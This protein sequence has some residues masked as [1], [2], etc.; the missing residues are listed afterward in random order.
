ML[1]LSYAFNKNTKSK[2]VDDPE[3]EPGI[4]SRAL[5]VV[6]VPHTFCDNI[7]IFCCC[8][9]CIMSV[10]LLKQRNSFHSDE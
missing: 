2:T 6:L 7:V 8:S 4:F 1:S 10:M 5:V 3:K 9:F